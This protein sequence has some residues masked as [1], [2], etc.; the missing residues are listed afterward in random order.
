MAKKN[1]S[2]VSVIIP[3]FNAEK[4]IGETLNSLANQTFQDFEIIVADDCSTDNSRAVVQKFFATFDDR[5]RIVKL[6]KNSGSPGA[7]R[8]FALTKAHGKYVYFLDSDD[9]LDKTALE[10]LFNVAENFEADVVH[11]EK[12]IVFKGETAEVH[13]FQTGEFVTE[14]TLETFDI[15]ERVKGFTQK[16]YVWCGLAT[17]FSADNSSS[18]TELS[19]PR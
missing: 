18:T 10:E 12:Y 9:L 2:A 3:M 16:R 7:P 13:S 15:G 17:N 8:N 11:V 1:N 19:S 5:L 4:Y 14:P 6:S